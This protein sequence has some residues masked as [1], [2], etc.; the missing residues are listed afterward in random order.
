MHPLSL[1]ICSAFRVD[2]MIWQREV[3]TLQVLLPSK[4]F[5]EEPA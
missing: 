4:R 5:A 2:V 1:M 3:S